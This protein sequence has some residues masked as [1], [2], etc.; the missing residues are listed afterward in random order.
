MHIFGQRTHSHLNNIGIALHA[1]VQC[2]SNQLRG[3]NASPATIV[4]LFRVATQTHDGKVVSC[5]LLQTSLRFHCASIWFRQPGAWVSLTSQ[6]E[7]SNLASVRTLVRVR[8]AFRVAQ[9]LGRQDAAANESRTWKTLLES[10]GAK[11]I[12]QDTKLHPS[13]DQEHGES[14]LVPVTVEQH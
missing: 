2:I 9:P 7:T 4:T 10:L 14:L 3:A 6:L 12:L 13:Q 8:L 11:D 1:Y 5:V